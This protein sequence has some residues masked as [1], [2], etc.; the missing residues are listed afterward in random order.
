MIKPNDCFREEALLADIHEAQA[1]EK[2]LKM[3]RDKVLH[4]L[5]TLYSLYIMEKTALSQVCYD[6]TSWDTPDILRTKGNTREVRVMVVNYAEQIENDC[7]YEI[8]G[9]L[10]MNKYANGPIRKKYVKV[11]MGQDKNSQQ[12]RTKDIETEAFEDTVRLGNYV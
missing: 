7:K 4:D 10:I 2:S 8:A 12:S 3:E 5:D 6:D 1:I 9:K 11:E